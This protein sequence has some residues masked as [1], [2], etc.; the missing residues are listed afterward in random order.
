[1]TTSR[2]GC[3]LSSSATRISGQRATRISNA[4]S[5]SVREDATDALMLNIQLRSREPLDAKE[6]SREAVNACAWLDVQSSCS[7][8]A[9]YEAVTSPSAGGHLGQAAGPGAPCHQ[10]MA[11]RSKARTS[12][13]SSSL[14]PPPLPVAAG[15]SDLHDGGGALPAGRCIALFQTH[16]LLAVAVISAHE[17]RAPTRG[18]PAARPPRRASLT[19]TDRAARSRK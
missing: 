5:W 2:H 15:R 11:W 19:C 12:R 6:I 1:V 9:R 10:C 14:E 7:D 17:A 3:P 8:Y 13:R 16:T 4:R 18:I